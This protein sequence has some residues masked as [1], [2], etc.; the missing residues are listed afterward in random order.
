MLRLLLKTQMKFDISSL[1]TPEAEVTGFYLECHGGSTRFSEDIDQWVAKMIDKLGPDDCQFLIRSR[2]STS[3][4]MW[5]VKGYVFIF[6]IRQA[7]RFNWGE[8]AVKIT[9]NSKLEA[10]RITSEDEAI[11]SAGRKYVISKYPPTVGAPT[12]LPDYV[13]RW[14]LNYGDGSLAQNGEQMRGPCDE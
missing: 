10:V 13:G 9:N 1:K 8:T 7:G 4:G 2:S 6:D 14:D 3:L 5:A 11:D 12:P